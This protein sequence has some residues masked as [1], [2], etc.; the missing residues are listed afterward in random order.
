MP[1]MQ[2]RRPSRPVLHLAI[3]TLPRPR[4]ASLADDWPQGP[5]SRTS[6]RRATRSAFTHAL[7]PPS[8]PEQAAL[9]SASKTIAQDASM[10]LHEERAYLRTHMY[11]LRLSCP[12]PP[13]LPAPD[14]VAGRPGSDRKVRRLRASHKCAFF[15]ILRHQI[16]SLQYAGCPSI[17]GAGTPARHT[18]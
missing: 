3:R 6:W 1:A 11:F 17:D 2:R 10:I 13:G 7:Y 18:I 5:V 4:A 14:A 16:D 12:M 9:G 8:S 15:V